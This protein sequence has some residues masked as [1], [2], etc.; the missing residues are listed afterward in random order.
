M[1]S[2]TGVRPQTSEMVLRGLGVLASSAGGAFC[3]WRLLLAS[4][5][6]DDRSVRFKILYVYLT[7][8]CVAVAAAELNLVP[9]RILKMALFLL[10]NMGR[11]LFYILLGT[12][13]LFSGWLGFFL[14]LSLLALGGINV[15]APKDAARYFAMD[16]RGIGESTMPNGTPHAFS[17]WNNPPP[18]VK[19]PATGVSLSPWVY[20]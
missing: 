20:Q 13:V 10:T 4:A 9:P 18:P 3:A 12:L 17:S 7:L 5:T 19:V 15:Y 1:A 8:L 6:D 16:P 14:G 2:R 11:G